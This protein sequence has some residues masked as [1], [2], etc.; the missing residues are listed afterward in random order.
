VEFA[1]TDTTSNQ[2]LFDGAAHTTYVFIAA[3]K[4][5]QGGSATITID[6][7][8]ISSG[9]DITSYLDGKLHTLVYA[10]TGI[11]TDI[12]HI[13]SRPSPSTFFNGTIANVKFT[14]KSGSTDVVQTFPL[15][16]L[17]D[18]E[19]CSEN[20]VGDNLSELTPA[21]GGTTFVSGTTVS[22]TKAAANYITSNFTYYTVGQPYLVTVTNKSNADP[23]NLR[24]GLG[25]LLTSDITANSTHIITPTDTRLIIAAG[26][27]SAFDGSFDITIRSVTNAVTLYNLPESNREF[28][29]LVDG[30]W[31]GNNELVTNGGFDTDSGWTKG[32]E[33]TIADGIASCDGSQVTNSQIMVSSN[34]AIDAGLVYSLSYNLTSV[35]AGLITYSHLGGAT[36]NADI[37]SS[38]LVAYNLTALDSVGDL[39]IAGD[40]AF[41]G[42]IDNVSVKRIILNS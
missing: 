34:I 17:D 13:G 20:E 37:T 7:A 29:N 38:G 42:S 32:S 16:T 31:V 8:S 5:Y 30:H 41:T 3:G 10:N 33:W 19:L 28:F 27:A 23:I 24:D 39:K 9:D 22:G 40:T 14:D 12:T 36:N 1:S 25:V 15:D 21:S 11:T 4:L 18:Y 35:S 2:Y 26:N 6:G